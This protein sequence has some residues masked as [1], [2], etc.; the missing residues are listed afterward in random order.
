MKVGNQYIIPFK[1]LKE[2]KHDFSFQINKLFFEEYAELNITGGS[3]VVNITLT[4]KSTFLVLNTIIEGQ[5]ELICD[6]CLETFS[7]KLDFEGQLFVKFKEEPEEPD[8]QVIFLHPN[9]DVLDLNQYLYDCI[10]LNIPIQKV[11]PEIN[12]KSGC[13]QEMISLIN[14][15]T[16]K[17][18][19]KEEKDPRWSKL[20]DLLNNG[21]KT[22]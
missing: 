2:G 18:I 21:N 12:G 5:I 1:G 15:H 3:L 14:K 7:N 4:K 16:T 17:K 8:D 19:E 10:G 13:N 9:E 6:R 11:H 20:R 22:E